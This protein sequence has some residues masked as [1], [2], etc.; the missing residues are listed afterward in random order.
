MGEEEHSR[1]LE[2]PTCAHQGAPR[3][4][5]A[6]TPAPR[7]RCR[8]RGSRGLPERSRGVWR[9]STESDAGQCAAR[10]VT[11]FGGGGGE[12]WVTPSSGPGRVPGKELGSPD[13]H[14][15]TRGGREVPARLSP[16]PPQPPSPAGRVVS[17]HPAGPPARGP[18]APARRLPVSRFSGAGSTPQRQAC[19]SFPILPVRD[20]RGRPRSLPSFRTK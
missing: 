10:S 2:T 3:P 1:P 4:S 16:V 11:G 13:C 18:C 20:R 19:Y 5:C 7:G 6:P 12:G 17:V 14:P 15:H 8:P 9:R